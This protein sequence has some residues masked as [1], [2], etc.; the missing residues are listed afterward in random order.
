MQKK[1]LNDNFVFC[2]FSNLE[3]CQRLVE[4]INHYKLDPMGGE[5]QSLSETQAIDLVNG[6]ASHSSCFVLFVLYDGRIVGLATCF[7]NFSTF[8]A[9]PYINIHDIIIEREYRGKGLGRTL[10]EKII[11]LA[12]EQNYCKVNL[13]V[14][15]DN[16]SAKQLY[17]SLGFQDTTPRMLFWTKML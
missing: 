17:A 12:Q 16:I 4:L 15:D 7:M 2:N 8:C 11:S 14:R 5:S 13:E 1:P 3:H 6:L 10:L 9:K